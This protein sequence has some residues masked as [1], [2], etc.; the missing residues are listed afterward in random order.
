VNLPLSSLDL[1]KG[2]GSALKNPSVE[3][4]RVTGQQVGD[5]IR[6]NLSRD[7]G[8]GVRPGDSRAP[9]VHALVIGNS[10]YPISP[11]PN[12]QNDARAISSR[13]KSF[14]IDVELVIDADRAKLVSTLAR[15][16][17]KVAD[18][19]LAI[20]FYAGHGVQINGV[21]YLLPVDLN[22][23]ESAGEI[24]LQGIS[25]STIVEDYLPSKAKLVFLD[26]CRDNPL[27]RSFAGRGIGR[28]L[29]PI[30]VAAGTLISY[31]T[32]DGSTAEDGSG[33]NS[34]YTAA[35]LEHLAAPDDISLVLRRV[36][37][38]VMDLTRGR[39]QPW[40]YGSLVGD[41][42]VLSTVAR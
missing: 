10:K 41:K 22:F 25:L 38:R 1:A 4:Q 16:G 42:L 31:A 23:V 5:S 39:Q 35:L 19:E 15:F 12:A 9:K 21:N 26:A 14:G 30:D 37:Q 13:L 29:A 40:E 36:R 8:R 11:L 24:T 28:G 18:S 20:L 6:D 34:P 7:G 33:K 27:S 17:R 3:Q 2:T 32:K